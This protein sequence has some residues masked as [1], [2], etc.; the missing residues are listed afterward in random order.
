MD[1]HVVRD[2]LARGMR[3]LAN[4]VAPDNRGHVSYRPP[5]EDRAYIIGRL[6]VGQGLL[7]DRRSQG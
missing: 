1:D 3:I 5:G 4:E 2:T 7:V 6:H